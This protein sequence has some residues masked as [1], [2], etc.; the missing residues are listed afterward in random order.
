MKETLQPG[1]RYEHKFIVPP[2]KTVP[3]LY[4]ESEEFLAMP[5]TLAC[6]TN[7]SEGVNTRVSCMVD[8]MS[9]ILPPDEN[10]S[11]S[12]GRDS[13]KLNVVF[14]GSGCQRKMDFF[15]GKRH[16]NAPSVSCL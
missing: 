13:G 1:L 7:A 4:P 2:S 10:C 9:D 14:F 3:A 16:E 5:D 15:A 12:A 11:A 8:W 6:S